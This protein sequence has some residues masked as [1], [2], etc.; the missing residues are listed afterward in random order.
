MLV[1]INLEYIYRL[2]IFYA[3]FDCVVWVW[4]F[5]AHLLTCVSNVNF[6]DSKYDFGG[7]EF[8]NRVSFADRHDDI[9]HA[10]EGTVTGHVQKRWK[11]LDFARRT[12]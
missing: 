2:F 1:L 5:F 9:L 7:E 10:V 4:I 11:S 6:P 8:D 3:T 12:L